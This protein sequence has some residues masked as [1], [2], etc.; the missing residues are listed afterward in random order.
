MGMTVE[1]IRSLSG[2]E[3]ENRL[4]SWLRLRSANERQRL[5]SGHFGSHISIAP[6]GAPS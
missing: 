4:G 6:H 1:S 5:A 3:A 2:V